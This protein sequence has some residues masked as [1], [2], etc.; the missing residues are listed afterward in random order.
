MKIA[1]GRFGT[2]K[3]YI[4]RSIGNF[5]RW[6]KGG[7]RSKGGRNR[8]ENDMP[9]EAAEEKEFQVRFYSKIGQ[10]FLVKLRIL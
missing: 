4:G 7:C 10:K 1:F 3:R 2:L 5:F 8:G 6:M 9:L